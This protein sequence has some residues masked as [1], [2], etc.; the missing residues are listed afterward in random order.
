MPDFSS[1]QTVRIQY[2]SIAVCLILIAG[3]IELIRRGRLREEYAFVWLGSAIVLLALSIWRGAFDALARF[4][5]IAYG[6][7]LL[8]LVILFF[9]FVFLVHFSI[10]VSRLTSENK[11]LAQEIAMLTKLVEERES[12]D[13]P[14]APAG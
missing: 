11:R 6:P 14:D 10:V 9:G 12:Q 4:L 7:A 2:I 5:G 8:I 1:V 3:I 13:G